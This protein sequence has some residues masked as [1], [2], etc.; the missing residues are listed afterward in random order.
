MTDQQQ[1]FAA[2]GEAIYR[3]RD[4]LPDGCELNI[5]LEL[6]EVGLSLITPHGGPGLNDWE[7]DS[8]AAMINIAVSYAISTHH[9][10]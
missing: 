4:E 9:R 3:A 7:G 2:L 10:G 6:G 1:R 5:S 8:L